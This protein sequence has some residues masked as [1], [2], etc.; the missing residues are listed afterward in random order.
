MASGRSAR[1]PPTPTPNVRNSDV[2]PETGY[3][4]TTATTTTI[5]GSTIN[6]LGPELAV[7]TSQVLDN[8]SDKERQMILEVLNRDE[9]VRQRD[10]ARIM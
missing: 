1:L 10:A 2:G 3:T 6:A 5:P 9:G 4:A 8:L 7:A